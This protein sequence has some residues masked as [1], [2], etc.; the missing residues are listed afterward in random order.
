MYSWCNL[1]TKDFHVALN[2]SFMKS[3]TYSNVDKRSYTNNKVDS[4]L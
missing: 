1:V 3:N 4:Q 2:Y